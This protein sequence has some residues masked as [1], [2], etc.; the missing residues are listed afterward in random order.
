MFYINKLC[1]CENV[2]FTLY[3]LNH[4]TPPP[5]IYES[6]ALLQAGVSGTQFYRQ[7]SAGHHRS[8]FR[9]IYYVIKIAIAQPVV[10]RFL[11]F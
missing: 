7:V 8:I 1:L 6:A 3:K 4:I 11:K 9:S 10:V 5:P 2:F